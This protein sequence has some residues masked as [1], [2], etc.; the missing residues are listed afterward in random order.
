MF[1]IISGTIVLLFC[2]QLS[3]AQ[4]GKIRKAD[5]L[6]NNYNYIE[7]AKRYKQL[8]SDNINV[9]RKEAES[10]RLVKNYAAAEK[11][12]RKIVS[13]DS[14]TPDDHYNYSYVL[15]ANKKYSES[16]KQLELFNSLNKSDSRGLF[17]VSDKN[18]LEKISKDEQRFKIKNLSFNTAAQEFSPTIY[19]NNLVFSSSRT[20]TGFSL[21]RYNRNKLPFLNIYTSEIKED[22]SFSKPKQFRK[23]INK[24]YHDGPA[25]FS[26]N[27]EMM[28]FTRNNY[29]KKASDGS[30]NLEIFFAY[31]K[32]GK[33]SKPVPFQY[34]SKEYSMGHPFLSPDGKT[35][36]FTSNMP[37]GIGGTDI[38]K[39]SLNADNSWSTPVNMGR[40]I[41]TEG[42]EMFP[43]VSAQGNLIFA[44][45]GHLGLGGLDLFIANPEQTKVV[46]MGVPLNTNADDFGFTADDK[47]QQ[48]YFSSNR[49]GGEG[50]DD[51]YSAMILK[52]FVFGKMIKGTV[53]DKEGNILANST[54]ILSDSEGKKI[55]S[56][57]TTEDGKYLFDVDVDQDFKLLGEKEGYFDGENTVNTETKDDEVLV[58]LI[59]EKDL[60]PSF[61]G[62]I[63]DSKTNHVLEGAKVT[64][65]DQITNKRDVFITSSSG[66]FRK[67]LAD[68]KLNDQGK[69]KFIIQKEGYFTKSLDYS[70]VF[71]KPGQ[72][73]VSTSL[74]FSSDDEKYKF[75]II[76]INP[77]YFE[78]DKYDIS[79]EVAKDLDRVVLIM[80]KYIDM[81]IE[82]ESHTDC[83]ASEAYNMNLSNNR[84]ELS[85]EYI[86]ARIVNPERVSGKGFGESK[87]VN[88]CKCEGEMIDPCTE[89]EHQL[90]R[91]IEFKVISTGND[92]V[93][94]E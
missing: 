38:Y 71:T 14:K 78:F 62:I 58:N 86:K 87:L 33:W 7:A 18:Y 84:A 8:D 16:D 54:V 21:R 74:D 31:Y 47:M 57:V 53:F 55:A 37:G 35:M 36:Y 44:S 12:Y 5:K 29:K 59:L 9:I 64:I 79:P 40:L 92:N 24:K 48:A 28:A 93:I 56:V 4:D 91:R 20:V 68:K 30:R 61:F 50:D 2:M 65:I 77:I 63:T 26:K 66:D 72:Y 10:Y 75:E 19:N 80:N 69:F 42:D 15:R 89:E 43:F 46:N 94:V 11:L 23:K 85:V 70:V 6:Y 60:K 25:S 73:D 27:G 81:V 3:L 83:R 1:K 13:M 88:Q 52:P 17:Y 90:N 45:D 22:G 32:D 82:L 49:D 67:T 39:S 76:Q 51:I 34:N 41:N